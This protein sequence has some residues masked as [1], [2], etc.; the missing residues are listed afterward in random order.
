MNRELREKRA[1]RRR[2]QG[3]PGNGP[4]GSNSVQVK[5]NPDELPDIK[6]SECEGVVFIPAQ[7]IKK[8]SAILSPDGQEKY[9][10]MPVAACLK[11]HAVLEVKP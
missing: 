11:C 10:Q 9:V 6:C 1:A 7:R 8:L 3:V 4:Q 2:A 5:V